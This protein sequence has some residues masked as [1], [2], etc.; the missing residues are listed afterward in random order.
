MNAR[1]LL[2]MFFLVCASDVKIEALSGEM[3]IYGGEFQMSRK[4]KA[5]Y[6]PSASQK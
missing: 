2:S 1:N 6:F 5:R 4:Q 3:W